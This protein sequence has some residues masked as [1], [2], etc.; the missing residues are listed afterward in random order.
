M[1]E[2]PSITD[3][4]RPVIFIQPFSIGAMGGGSRILRSVIMGAPVQVVSIC[5][6]FLHSL[7]ENTLCEEH[8]V[9]QRPPLGRLDRTRF[10]HWGSWAERACSPWFRARL[11]A[12]FRAR[13]PR[14]VHLVPHSWGDFA[15]A[16]DIA[17]EMR[18][19]VHAS[20]HDDFAYTAGRHCFKPM[21]LEKLGVLWREAVTRFVI[22]EEIGE[23]Y[24]RRYGRREYVIHTDGVTE[25]NDGAWKPPGDEVKM[26]FMGMM[27][28]PYIETVRSMARA[29][30]LL[31]S[32]TGRK[33]SFTLRT[34]GY[35]AEEGEKVNLQPCA[36]EDVV[37]EELKQ[38]DLLYLPLPLGEEYE[39]LWRYGFSTKMVGY[40][41]SGTPVVYHG[42]PEA[43]ISR[44][45]ARNETAVQLHSTDPE[46]IAAVLA[47]ALSSPD[48]LRQLRDNALRVARRDFDAAALHRRFWDALAV[49]KDP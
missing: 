37:R 24:C 10:A 21:L 3:H 5:T 2:A 36:S 14:A 48:G 19:P 12:I 29:L 46:Q 9:R 23:E 25:V 45:L 18:V 44:Y 11:R 22:S 1:P 39:G 17:R 26:Y 35:A 40:L 38:Q 27:N 16:H 43:A 6:G 4:S 13:Q 49:S 33:V 42:H 28:Y 34:H 47:K 30:P 32:A 8:L 20:F 7:P 41:A 31:E 15:V